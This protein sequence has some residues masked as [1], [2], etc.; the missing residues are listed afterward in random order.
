MNFDQFLKNEPAVL[1]MLDGLTIQDIENLK[2]SSEIIRELLK[3]APYDEVYKNKLKYET[4]QRADKRD[5]L[6]MIYQVD[7][8][9]E[10]IGFGKP[11]LVPQRHYW[12]I[13]VPSPTTTSVTIRGINWDKIPDS[14]FLGDRSEN[15]KKTFKATKNGIE[16]PVLRTI[17][18]NVRK[19]LF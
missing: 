17:S 5:V 18:K 3:H 12:P 7:P 15:D 19:Q 4:F 2:K 8:V 1:L 10:E 6:D 14:Y 16:Y 9:L 11:G 13:N